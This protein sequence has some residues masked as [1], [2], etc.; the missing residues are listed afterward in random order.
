M[1]ESERLLHSLVAGKI[2]RIG[3]LEISPSE[4]G[5]IL[6]HREDVGRTDLKNYEIDDALEVAKFDDAKSY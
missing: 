6:C 2:S 3:Q 4:G 5:F 1:K